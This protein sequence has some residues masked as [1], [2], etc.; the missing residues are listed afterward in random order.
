[1]MIVSS[2]LNQ[3]TN[4][5]LGTCIGQTD[6]AINWVGQTVRNLDYADLTL[7]CLGWYSYDNDVQPFLEKVIMCLPTKTLV[8]GMICTGWVVDIIYGSIESAVL[9]LIENSLRQQLGSAL[10]VSTA[11]RII[12]SPNFGP[13]IFAPIV[14]EVIVRGIYMS[15]LK[16]HFRL[17]VLNVSGRQHHYCP[18]VEM[19]TNLLFG[20]I[21]IRDY[22]DQLKAL[23]LND[24]MDRKTAQKI[25]C[26]VIV[27]VIHTFRLSLRLYTPA[28]ERY[29]LLA[30][31]AAHFIINWIA[32]NSNIVRACSA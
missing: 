18:S 29:G 23:N 4:I 28:Y 16:R 15:I 6:A 27:H 25:L 10:Q 31:M 1:M 14:E 20:S 13:L 12:M 9:C 11:A 17:G 30:S 3:D 21:H 5:I 2:I 26:R 32:T 22:T 24:D 7:R 19:I 8:Q